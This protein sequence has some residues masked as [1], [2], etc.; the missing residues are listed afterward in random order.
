MLSNIVGGH[1]LGMM[2]VILFSYD[3]DPT[4]YIARAHP[5]LTLIHHTPKLLTLKMS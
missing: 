4:I 2:M 1:L 5:R 3:F